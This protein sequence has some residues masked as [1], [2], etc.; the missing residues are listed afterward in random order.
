MSKIASSL[1]TCFRPK[2]GHASKL[3]CHEAV[4]LILHQ[5]KDG[6]NFS[7]ENGPELISYRANGTGIMTDISYD[8]R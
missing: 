6:N 7:A 8:E 2:P 5:T 3:P 1:L 4:F